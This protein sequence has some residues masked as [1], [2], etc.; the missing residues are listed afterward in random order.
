MLEVEAHNRGHCLAL[1][2]RY[3]QG[4][5]LTG[6][7]GMQSDV[8]SVKAIEGWEEHFE[9]GLPPPPDGAFSTGSLLDEFVS[10]QG[11]AGT[12]VIPHNSDFE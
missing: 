9:H 1:S 11:L 2:T 8:A 6:H 7:V 5:G 4:R 3:K 12:V 10:R